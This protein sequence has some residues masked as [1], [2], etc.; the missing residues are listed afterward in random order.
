MNNI[1]STKE[2][3]LEVIRR[4]GPCLPI[5]ISSEIKL[6]MLFVS[7]FL[8][9]L[10][11]EK[12]IRISNMKVGGSPIYY[13][14]EQKN[15]LENFS[16]H[17]PQKEKEAFLLLKE[18]R[19]LLDE[20][21]EPAIRVALRNIKDFA[22]PFNLNLGEGR[23]LY[24]R[25][26]NVGEEEIRNFLEKKESKKHTPIVKEELKKEITK[27]KKEK[28]ILEL[29]E[30]IE[31]KKSK[32]KEKSDFVNNVLSL[33]KK[34]GIEIVEEKTYK[35]KEYE[36]VIKINSQLG[37]I[38]FFLIAKDKKRITENDLTLTLQKAQT[39]K[40]PALFLS[41]G[42]LNKKAAQYLEQYSGLLKFKRFNF[43]SF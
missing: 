21:Q 28:P 25:F 24:W 11:A 42:E 7:A 41:P 13:L 18:K 20:K 12:K 36:A 30:K 19:I 8:S 22:V 33:L 38:P 6:E 37:V 9:E 26:Y 29:K 35:K 10:A 40:M 34:E 16:K 5:H 43:K 14:P 27:G 39:L 23:K 31:L 32:K 4:K 2:R 17:L 3:I 1:N 15:Q